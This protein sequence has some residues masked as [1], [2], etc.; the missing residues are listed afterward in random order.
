MELEQI[1][2]LVNKHF[3]VDITTENR[4]RKTVMARGAYY[5]IAS[6]KTNKSFTKIG[7]K[8]NRCHAT[9]L[10]SNKNFHHWLSF[11]KDFNEEFEVFKKMIFKN[12]TIEDLI[13]KKLEYKHKMIK[14][15][16]ELLLTEIKRLKEK[17][18]GKN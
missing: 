3:D 13:L 16:K 4:K 7:K 8:V 18:N 11:D 15:A 5:W 2:E 10:H 6:K 1:I 17:Q 12:I 9:V 14:I